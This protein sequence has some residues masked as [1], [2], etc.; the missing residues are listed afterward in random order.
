MKEIISGITSPFS[1][2]DNEPTN[3]ANF[4]TTDMICSYDFKDVG[5]N[6]GV[7]S[8]VDFCAQLVGSRIYS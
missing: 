2:G 7:Y 3:A 6:G 1:W 8:D 4:S 5:K